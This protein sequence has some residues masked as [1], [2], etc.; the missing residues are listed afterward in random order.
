M[1]VG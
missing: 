1:W